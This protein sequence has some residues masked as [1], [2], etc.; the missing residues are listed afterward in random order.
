MWHAVNIGFKSVMIDAND[1]DIVIIAISLM[2]SLKAQGLEKLWVKFGKGDHTRWLPMHDIVDIIGQEKARGILLFHAFTGCDLISAFNNK[3]KK[4]AWQT[5]N[6][7][8]EISV[9]FAQLSKVPSEIDEGNLRNLERYVVLM[10][11]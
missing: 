8:P 9:T 3:G 2:S 5:W 1:T 6:V 10:Y 7:Y 11:D 4:C